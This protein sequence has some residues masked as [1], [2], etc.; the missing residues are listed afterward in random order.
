MRRLCL[1]MMVGALLALPGWAQQSDDRTPTK[2][3]DDSAAAT[4]AASGDS[5]NAAPDA[6]RSFAL[7]DAPRATPFPGPAS[8]PT[9]DSGHS[10]PGRFD[11]EMGT[12]RNVQLHQFQSGRGFPEFQQ[13][14]RHWLVHVQLQQVARSDRVKFGAYS[15]ERR[16]PGVTKT[17]GGFQTFLVGPRM[18]LRRDHFV[19]FAEV[20]FGDLRAGGQ[21]TGGGSQQ[22]V[23]AGGGRRRGHRF[24]QAHRVALCADRLSAQL[25]IG[26]LARSAVSGRTASASAPASCFVGA[27]RH[28]R[29]HRR[30]DRRP[31]PA[32]RPRRQSSRDRTIRPRFT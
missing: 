17:E 1:M 13:Q 25:R 23:R 19:P 11:T 14:R 5:T 3:S 4:P 28:H 24:H 18:N 12:R 32:R 21:V 9:S 8:S 30:P 2:S 26:S 22:L 6:A 7:P 10:T 15:F 27:S 31:L 16:I 29:R 20:L